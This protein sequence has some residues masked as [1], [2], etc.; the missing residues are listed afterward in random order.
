MAGMKPEG[1]RPWW[2]GKKR[3]WAQ[4]LPCYGGGVGQLKGGSNPDPL[5][6]YGSVGKAAAG[7][8]FGGN[9]IAGLVCMADPQGILALCGSR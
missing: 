2:V 7:R 4:A 9:G 5:M 1:C 8:V 6:G 3:R